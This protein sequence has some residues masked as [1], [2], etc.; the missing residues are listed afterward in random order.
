MMRIT[1]ALHFGFVDILSRRW[2]RSVIVSRIPYSYVAER[3]DPAVVVRESITAL[4]NISGQSFA[5][6][7]DQAQQIE[8]WQRWLSSFIAQ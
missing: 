4:E 2:A 6:G 3:P 1:E 7:R 5:D 8:A